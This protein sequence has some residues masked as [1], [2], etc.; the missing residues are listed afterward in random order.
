MLFGP[1]ANFKNDQVVA[2]LNTKQIYIKK[3][4]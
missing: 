4:W 2:D 3:W 1:I